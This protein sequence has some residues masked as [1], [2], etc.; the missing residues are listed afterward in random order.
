MLVVLVGFGVMIGRL[1]EVTGGA[2]VLALSPQSI[3]SHDSFHKSHGPFAFPL[4]AVAIVTT[5]VSIAYPLT[6][7][8]G[9]RLRLS[10]MRTLTRG[11]RMYF[12]YASVMSFWTSF[13]LRHLAGIGSSMKGSEETFPFSSTSVVEV[14]SA[15]PKKRWPPRPNT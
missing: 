2:Q 3:E 6:D 15:W 9:G 1:L 13:S 12:E 11:F 14:R 10:R 4:L 5:L 8:S 7:G